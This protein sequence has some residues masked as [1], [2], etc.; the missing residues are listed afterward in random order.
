MT[1]YSVIANAEGAIA[2]PSLA[3]H[4]LSSSSCGG[5]GLQQSYWL[6]GSVCQRSRFVFPTSDASILAESFIGAPVAIRQ[7]LRLLRYKTNAHPSQQ[8][9]LSG[10][11][12]CLP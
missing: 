1:K 12:A 2:L 4:T 11:Q 3:E 7:L 5:C 6:R 9:Y 10:S 8:C